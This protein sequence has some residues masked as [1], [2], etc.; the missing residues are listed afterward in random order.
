MRSPLPNSYRLLLE[1]F[2]VRVPAGGAVSEEGTVVDRFFVV[3]S[4]RVAVQ[5]EDA[6]GARSA[7]REGGPGSSVGVAA[8]MT[9]RPLFAGA[10]AIEAS[11]LLAIPVDEAEE[12]FR[13]APELAVALLR[14]FS[15]QDCEEGQ[16]GP[17]GAVPTPV[18]PSAV[19]PE[20][21]PAEPPR[22]EDA[23][24]VRLPVDEYDETS[25][26]VDEATCPVSQTRFQYLRTRAGAVRPVSR[27]S[28][29][30]IAYRTIDPGLYAIGFC[31]GCSFAAYPDDFAA[32]T[33]QERAA[34]VA[35]QPS[36]DVFGRPNLGGLRTPDG[37]VLALRLARACYDV[38]GAGPRRRAG[39][40]HRQAWIER[41]RGKVEA[42]RTLL[43]EAREA[44]IAAFEQDGDLSDAAAARAAYV[45]GDLALRLDD[46]LEAA[47]WLES[48]VRMPELAEQR[49]LERLAR[50]RLH[51]ARELLGRLKDSA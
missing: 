13:I 48:C 51:E 45:I 50:D 2:G 10:V 42:E 30:R 26:F 19:D 20:A 34:L 24:L 33:E 3:L 23:G 6:S 25:F 7:A 17:P 15:W 38:R 1:R 4:G 9:G 14:E 49:G 43:R 46:P 11:E 5:V 27:D 8:A 47:R 36:R 12:A 40:L 16:A 32:V 39:L 21:Q 44:Y 18:A 35:A 41:A 28:D 37:G 31:P 22:I 29:F